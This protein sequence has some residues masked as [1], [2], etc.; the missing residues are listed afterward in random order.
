MSES[1]P[2]RRARVSGLALIVVAL[3]VS[4]CGGGGSR[5][6]TSATSSAGHGTASKTAP[7]STD[8]PRS[9]RPPTRQAARWPPA[10]GRTF[11]DHGDC[12]SFT[13]DVSS[14]IESTRTVTVDGQAVD[15]FVV[16]SSITTHGQVESTGS[17]RDWFSPSLRLS[18]HEE[19]HQ[20]GT[21]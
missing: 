7:S 14:R 17:Q 5:R 18:V 21:F 1:P 20:Q 3:V 11:A 10:V 9:T 19:S 16:Q 2:R 6:L 8:P 13:T 12:G 15:T 4:A